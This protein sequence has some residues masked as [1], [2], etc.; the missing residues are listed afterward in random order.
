MST[1]ANSKAQPSPIGE[2]RPVLIEVI[3]DL[4][5][6]RDHGVAKYKTE[7]KT[8]NG[9]DPLVD[10]YQELLD[11][12]MYIKQTLME[13]PK[14]VIFTPRELEIARMAILSWFNAGLPQ[15][16]LRAAAPLMA[17]NDELQTLAEKLRNL[18]AAAVTQ[19]L[20]SR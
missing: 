16:M 18:V 17:Q 13:C 5:L 19:P 20:E 3:S 8:G 4:C 9:R 12:V 10:L 15:S 2:G 7:L 11:A 1:H 6:R 14:D